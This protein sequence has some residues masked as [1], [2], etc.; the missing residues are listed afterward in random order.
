MYT[1]VYTYIHIRTY[2]RTYIR[3]QTRISTYIYKHIHTYIHTYIHVPKY[4]HTHTHTHTQ[5]HTHTHTHTHKWLFNFRLYSQAKLCFCE[6]ISVWFEKSV[7]GIDLKTLLVS[8]RNLLLRYIYD[9]RVGLS[10]LQFLYSNTQFHEAAPSSTQEM[11]TLIN[12]FPYKG[13]W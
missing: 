5:T 3:T 4:V 1:Y 13:L 12:Y 7:V 10:T 2:I 11:S 9:G 8:W 6:D